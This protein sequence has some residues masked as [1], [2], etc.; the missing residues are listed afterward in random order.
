M[1]SPRFRHVMWDWNGTLFNDAPLCVDCMN[2]LLRKRALPLLT[3][4]R[5][6]EVF[7]FPVVDY[8]RRLGFDFER[9]PFEKLGTE[10]MAEY[11]LRKLECPLQRD[12]RRVLD[13]LRDAGLSQSVLSAYQQNTLEG[14]LEHF[15]VRPYFIRVIGADDHYASGKLGRGMDW[16]RELGVN[17]KDVVLVGDTVHDFEVARAM[18]T[19]C[20]LIPC[21]NH[22]RAKLARCGVPV[23][24]GLA[25]VLDAVFE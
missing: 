1:P 17:P 20:L 7:D 2:T 19:S 5:Y 25:G 14:L 22:G 6:E 9:E 15:H 21:G 4:A 10:F 12:A 24:D 3:P 13:G 11:E 23:L 18:G 8:Y 16:I